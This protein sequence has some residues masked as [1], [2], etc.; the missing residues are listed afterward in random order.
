MSINL[1]NIELARS[2]VLLG[3]EVYVISPYYNNGKDGK[4]PGAL[5]K[6]EFIKWERNIVTYILL[7]KIFIFLTI[8]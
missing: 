2:L 4:T 6:E 7:H 8:K 1:L 3:C 5:A